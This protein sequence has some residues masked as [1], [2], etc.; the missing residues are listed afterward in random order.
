METSDHKE[1]NFATAHVI[2]MFILLCFSGI[3]YY[4]LERNAVANGSD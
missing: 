2:Y 4:L 1:H 3:V